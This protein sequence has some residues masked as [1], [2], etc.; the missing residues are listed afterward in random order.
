MNASFDQEYVG[1]HGC[2]IV[3]PITV[4]EGTPKGQQNLT[5]RLV[6][7]FFVFDELFINVYFKTTHR[8]LGMGFDMWLTHRHEHNG[9][10]TY[11]ADPVTIAD[12]DALGKLTMEWKAM[13]E[14]PIQPALLS[15]EELPDPEEN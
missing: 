3:I 14:W 1:Y 12:F 4:K 7:N 8:L 13:R 6:R 10:I 9:L 11:Y 5:L 15:F 2:R